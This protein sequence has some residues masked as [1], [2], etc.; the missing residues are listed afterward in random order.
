[1]HF[2]GVTIFVMCE[3][4]VVD[5]TWLLCYNVNIVQRDKKLWIA[6][7]K[8][9]YKEQ[10]K[11][12]FNDFFMSFHIIFQLVWQIYQFWGLAPGKWRLRY[13]WH[14]NSVSLIWHF[15]FMHAH[16]IKDPSGS[17]EVSCLN[18]M[19]LNFASCADVD[20]WLVFSTVLFDRFTLTSDVFFH[21]LNVLSWTEEIWA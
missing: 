19:N 5:V 21:E 14:E 16:E 20:C 2:Y 4:Y 10:F 11:N 15:T 12:N 18:I 8:E 13:F 6:P 17:R 7:R 3:L 1:M 9:R